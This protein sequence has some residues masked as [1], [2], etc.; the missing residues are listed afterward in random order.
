MFYV[1]SIFLIGGLQYGIVDRF[2]PDRK[3][4]IVFKCAVVATGGV[5]IISQLFAGQ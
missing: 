4:A 1:L 2:E 3:L 5:A